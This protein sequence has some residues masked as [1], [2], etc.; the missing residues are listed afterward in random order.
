MCELIIRSDFSAR[1]CFFLHVGYIYIFVLIFLISIFLIYTHHT[2][3][4]QVD[5][6]L[7]RAPPAGGVG[8]RR[9]LAHRRDEPPPLCVYVDMTGP[10]HIYIHP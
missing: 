3:N 4:Q 2:Q 6:D 10:D 8:H 7:P 5:D 9:A 1:T